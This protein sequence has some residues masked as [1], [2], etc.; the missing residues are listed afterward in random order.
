MALQWNWDKKCGEAVISCTRNDVTKIFNLNL[1]QGNALLIFLYEFEEN[2][3]QYWDMS[4]FWADK[5]H[6]KNC[7]GLNKKM[8]YKEN[9]CD[10]P[11]WKLVK[12]SL[13]KS[14]CVYVKEIVTALVQA[15]DD[16]EINIYKG[17]E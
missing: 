12:I 7:L 15:F 4:Q 8:H 9:L 16:I 11:E 10:S 2:G 6:M 14:R 5:T 17:E 1:Y 13:N 3:K